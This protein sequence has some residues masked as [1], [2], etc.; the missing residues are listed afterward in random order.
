[1]NSAHIPHARA[2]LAVFFND[3]EY[4]RELWRFALPIVLQNLITSSLNLG[5]VVM[6]GQLGD[7]PVAAVGLANQVFFLF[8]LVLFGINS[9]AAMF[10]AQ[11]WGKRDLP[12]IRK[13]LS[14]ALILG[15]SVATLF[16][17]ASHF[18]PELVMGVYSK[19]LEV[20]ALGSAYLRIFGWSYLLMAVS[21]GFAMVLRSTGNVRLPV[22]VSISAF[23]FN[24]L[25]S[26]LLI[27]GKIG[28]PAM[29]VRGAALAGLLARLLEFG[30]LLGI[31]YLRRIPIAPRLT[32]LRS[33]NL[34]FAASLF[35]RI[36]PVI[37]NETFWST[38]ITAY[39]VVY[40]RLGTDSIAAMN[41]VST[42]DNLALVAIF[43]VANA[44]AIMVGNRIGAGEEEKA[45]RSAVR[46]LVISIV[47]GILIGGV[48]ILA[49]SH[50]LTLY[51]VSD[52]VIEYA[53]RALIILGLFLWVRGSNGLIVVGILRGGG[54][55]LF[56][57]LLDGM[58]IW[59]VGVPL[60]FFTAFVLDWPVYL[61][62]L[63]ILSEEVIKFCAGCW[64]IFSKRWI[65]NLTHRVE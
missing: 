57:F 40:G 17:A 61:V 5:S 21:F 64:R 10:T 49:S 18:I 34:S 55:T 36:L 25:L 20:I 28:F 56:S 43:G 42:I 46:S 60:A 3:R 45:Y 44:T 8:E 58:V 27:F 4:F 51:R 35:K 53:R 37:L 54:D 13:T 9:G 41:I 22:T 15:M 1:M 29:G 62:Y 38:G 63:A 59:L 7:A 30:V 39:Y 32:D 12:N 26:Y 48:V 47:M 23:G 50:I 24:I 33:L 31:V 16:L 2:N 6:I 52:Q 19:D 65:H 14:L 11:F